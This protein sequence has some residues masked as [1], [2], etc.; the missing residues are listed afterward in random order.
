MM[1]VFSLPILGFNLSFFLQHLP[2]S[3]QGSGFYFIFWF[4]HFFE[5]GVWQE[6]SPGPFHSEIPIK[7]PHPYSYNIAIG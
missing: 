6:T 2:F 3:I 5:V 7:S 1:I 4:Q